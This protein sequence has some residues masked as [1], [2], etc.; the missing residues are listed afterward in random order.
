[1][2]GERVLIVDDNPLNLK[3]M[4]VLLRIEGY[5]VRTSAD[6][7]E[8]LVAVQTFGPRVILM[9]VQMP[10]IDGLELTRRLKADPS[11]Q[12]ILIVALTAY[13]MIG[14]E[15]RARAAGCDAYVTKPL[16]STAFTAMLAELLAAS[17]P[18]A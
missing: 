9:D 8:A 17:D 16:D 2:A 1:M 6:A 18:P 15:T 5:D 14:D 10:G 11:T 12:R 13:A 3:L 4:Q 7:T